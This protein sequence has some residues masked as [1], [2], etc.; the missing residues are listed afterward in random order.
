MVAD[1]DESRG[2]LLAQVLAESGYAVV[3]RVGAGAYLPTFVADAEPDVVLVN[4]DSP[5]RDTLEQLTTIRRDRPRPVV[6]FATDEHTDTIRAAVKAGVSTYLVNGM[7]TTRV[8][9][10]IEVA[11]AH[12][13]EHQTLRDELESTKAS[14][15]ERKTLDRAK[16]ILMQRRGCSEPEAFALLRKAAMDQK[17]RI[18]QVAHDIVEMTRLLSPN[19]AAERSRRS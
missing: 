11:I 13:K 18:G 1:E 6:M 15:L 14:L 2:T 8:A 16:G 4:T 12:F 7:S 5:S 17:K 10:V 3:A 9:P 19:D